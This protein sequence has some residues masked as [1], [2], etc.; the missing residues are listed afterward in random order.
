MQIYYQQ[1]SG[2][3]VT[4]DATQDIWSII[5]SGTSR[6]RLHGWE[7]RS[8]ATTAAIISLN[9]HRITAAGTGGNDST[10]E[11]KLDERYQTPTAN[12]RTLDTTP[13]TDGGGLMAYQ[14]EQLGVVGH[15]WT[16]E[17]RPV[18]AVSQGFAL[19]W[20]TATAATLSGWLC[21]EEL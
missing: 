10:T 12:V 8:A 21:W 6:V 2:L 14:W 17:M 1:F 11:E 3:S 5:A 15:V 4:T 7:L 20:N 16:P 13:G 9:L 18:S 19:T